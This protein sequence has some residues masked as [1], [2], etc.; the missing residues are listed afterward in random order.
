MDPRTTFYPKIGRTFNFVS[1]LQ[2]LQIV[3]EENNIYSY[4]IGGDFNF[5]TSERIINLPTNVRVGERNKLTDREERKKQRC[6]NFI[7]YKDTFV[8]CPTTILTVD[9]IQALDIE[10]MFD[11]EPLPIDNEL[12]ACEELRDSF[13]AIDISDD[14]ENER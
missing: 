10:L 3:V 9:K 12:T 13:E 1:L 7:P 5:D 4:I 11:D 2:F 6:S 8:Y 14:N